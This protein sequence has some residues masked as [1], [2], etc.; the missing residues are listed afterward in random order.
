MRNQLF[1]TAFVLLLT[2]AAFTN[3]QAQQRQVLDKIV[4]VVNDQIILKSE[5]DEQIGEILSARR[6]MQFS[7]ELWFEVLEN[8]I[9]NNVMYEQAK[10][11]S[12]VVTPD[13]VNRVMDQRIQ[14]LIG[15][16]GSEQ[17]LEQAM[18]QS[19]IQVRAD[20]RDRFRRDMM[21][22]R[23][24]QQKL[25]SVRITRPEV[26]AFFNSIP[27]DSLPVVPETVELSHIVAIP[28]VFDEAEVAARQFAE[29]LRDSLLNHG[30][31]FETFA[32][33]YSS[34]P[35]ANRGGLIPMLPLSDLVPEYAA[36]ASALE[37]GGISQVVRTNA[38]FHIIRLNRRSGDQIETNQILIQVQEEQ[39]DENFA[40][41]RLT[42]IRDS[43]LVHGKTFP[44]MARRHSEDPETSPTGGRII[45]QQTGQRRL[46]VDEL[47][48][49]LYRAIINLEG[50]GDITEPIRYTLRSGQNRQPAFRIIRL[51]NR[52]PE[53]VANL[54]IDY[55]IIRNIALQDKQMRE[56]S[57]WIQNIREDMFIEYRIASPRASR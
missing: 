20:Y 55:D 1:L 56:L 42:A 34:G 13:E 16:A 7:E 45:N 22:D 24:R 46:A 53:H 38:G 4:A 2:A 48:P 9:D 33:R 50:E 40:I 39:V 21:V 30:A 37:P 43:V 41:E 17:A 28:P 51:N 52:I 49:A 36:A 25:R 32:R 44:Q 27:A 57:R 47:E 54:D 18:G 35:G 14:Q 23:L 19:L 29:S 8:I 15:Q 31:D 6:D 3:A 10:I 11:D 12:I 5:V 26:V